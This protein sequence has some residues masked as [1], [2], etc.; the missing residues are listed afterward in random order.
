MTAGRL[1]NGES[2]GH[3]VPTIEFLCRVYAQVFRFDH[4]KPEDS[5]YELGGHSLDAMQVVARVRDEFNIELPMR[6]VFERPRV[7]DLALSIDECRGADAGPTARV[8]PRDVQDVTLP[9]SS[10]QEG[11]WFVQQMNPENRAYHFQA[12]YRLNG[13][14]DEAALE[15]ALRAMT[16]RHEILRTSFR[17]VEGQPVQVI[18][19]EGP[20]DLRKIDLSTLS[21]ANA[22]ERMHR[23]CYEEFR[24]P[25]DLEALPLMR[26]VLMCLSADEYVI[27]H[28]EHHMIH[29]GWSF[30]VFIPELFEYYR[31]YTCNDSP[32]LAS[33]AL[34]FADFAAW[35]RTWL[36]SDEETVPGIRG[37]GRVCLIYVRSFP[38]G[39]GTGSGRA[40]M[41][42]LGRHGVRGKLALKVG[43]PAYPLGPRFA[44]PRQGLARDSAPS[45]PP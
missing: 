17:S 30:N 7:A 34:Q 2:E 10:A 3:A 19:R 16:A 37:I 33:P 39:A 22:A 1:M 20:V 36:E 11:V 32:M 26:F 42:A 38:P 29:D 43:E 12:L 28:V 8:T 41:R 35:Q 4:V 9:V 24:R 5:F 23:L 18:H 14:L 27:A 44:G 25:F 6:T 45:I 13:Q 21:K 40:G 31:A 15:L